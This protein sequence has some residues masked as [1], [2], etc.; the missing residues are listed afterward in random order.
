MAEKILVTGGTGL[1]GLEACRLAIDRG[2]QVVSVSRRGRPDGY[3][4]WMEAVTWVPAD[5][6]EPAAWAAHLAGCLGV[7][8][9][10]G[11]AF[12]QPGEGITF[13]RLNGEAAKEAAAA[14][15]RAGVPRFALVSAAVTP[16]FL[17]ERYLIAKR[18]AEADLRRRRL[19]AAILRPAFVYGGHRPW[20]VALGEG[21]RTLAAVPGLASPLASLRPLPVRHV[22]AAALEAVLTGE[23]GVLFQADIERLAQRF[24]AR[25][26]PV[27]PNRTFAGVAAGVAAGVLA[28]AALRTLWRRR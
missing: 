25:L 7:V 19:Q 28:G 12:E 6:L 17:S 27:G 18:G 5:V 20:S 26:R 4:A 23:E 3:Q 11:I 1:I 15:E 13:E 9:C 2:H 24:D 16:P 21:L 14:A 10:V 8:H 22:A